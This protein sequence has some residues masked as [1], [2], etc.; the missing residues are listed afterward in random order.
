MGKN[1]DSQIFL[2]TVVNQGYLQLSSSSISRLNT[3]FQSFLRVNLTITRSLFL[4]SRWQLSMNSA[5]MEQP[6]FWKTDRTF[7]SRCLS[8]TWPGIQTTSTHWFL[9]YCAFAEHW[10]SNTTIRL[11]NSVL[12]RLAI[13]S[14]DWTL[15]KFLLNLR[16]S[17]TTSLFSS[18]ILFCNDLLCPSSDK[19]IRISS[20]LNS[21]SN[22]SSMYWGI[23]KIVAR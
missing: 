6:T 21:L 3:C 8:S 7:T 9:E 16:I 20:L 1:F 13:E 2:C 22:D 15:E 10:R 11:V 4:P 5:A 14:S 19:T 12:T 17:S 23:V 18:N